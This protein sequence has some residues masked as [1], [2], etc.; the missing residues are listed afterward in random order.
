MEP[1]DTSLPSELILRMAANG[2]IGDD[3][4]ITSL[5][6]LLL[7]YASS[8]GFCCILFL[9]FTYTAANPGSVGSQ[10]VYGIEIWS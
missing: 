3:A 6:R 4:E 1:R 10:R 8:T 5:N 9:L 7:F 2:M